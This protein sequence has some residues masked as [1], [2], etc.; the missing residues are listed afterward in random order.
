MR[1]VQ[2]GGGKAVQQGIDAG[3]G[4]MQA[5]LQIV[6]L[7]L[8]GRHLLVQQFIGSLQFCVSEQ[9]ALDA[10]GNLVKVGGVGLDHEE[11]T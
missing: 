2:D 10:V 7:A 5:R 4:S 1:R 8:Q 3:A 9:Q 6:A 11:K